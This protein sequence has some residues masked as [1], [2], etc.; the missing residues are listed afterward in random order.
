M[1]NPTI[2]APMG[3]DML[4]SAAPGLLGGFN[5]GNVDIFLYSPKKID[6]QVIRPYVYQ[7]NENMVDRMVESA[8][9][10]SALKN[11]G[12]FSDPNFSSAIR[13][14]SNGIPMSM[15][16][17][18]ALW[19]FVLV[20]DL[21]LGAN[22]AGIVASGA[23]TRLVCTGWCS[24]EPIDPRTIHNTSPSPNYNC[25]FTVTH[26]TV[27]RVGDRIGALGGTPQRCITDDDDFIGGYLAN[28]PMLSNKDLLLAAPGDVL[29][30]VGDV[31]MDANGNPISRTTM[32]GAYAV[33]AIGDNPSVSLPTRLKS[34]RHHLQ[35]IV[36][37]LHSSVELAKQSEYGA[38]SDVT[39]AGNL[40]C[41]DP[42]DQAYND[43]KAQLF[44][45]AGTAPRCLGLDVSV[46]FTLGQLNTI[47][48]NSRLWPIMTRSESQWDVVPQTQISAK[49]MFSSLVASTVSTLAV[50]EGLAYIHFGFTSQKT[51]LSS[52]PGVFRVEIAG[53]LAPDPNPQIADAQ[54]AAAC[55]RFKMNLMNDLFPILKAAAN[56]TDFS[57]GCRYDL[58]SETLVDLHFLDNYYSTEGVGYYE[59]NNRLPVFATPNLSNTDTFVNN[60]V[61]LQCLGQH[62]AGRKLTMFG[63]NQPLS[64]PYHGGIGVPQIVDAPTGGAL[65]DNTMGSGNNAVPW[66]F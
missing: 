63:S 9:P 8:D 18:S 36:G 59:T 25:V 60:G 6:T 33:A 53:L 28:M 38:S 39:D 43:Y 7:F 20:I 22:A 47:Y 16:P 23:Q 58:G 12:I 45:S 10:R 40:L 34:P 37:A 52:E 54:L 48:P 35:E 5:P 50:G 3:G 64:S 44:R 14:E 51:S 27:L 61:Q 56:D 32:E 17:M 30:G 13:P 11:G 65:I 2:G 66:P 31:T 41:I 24:D 1:F 15:A 21:P 55:Q 19:T 46:P 4:G 49:I 26:R 62:V 29:G 42:I 57:L